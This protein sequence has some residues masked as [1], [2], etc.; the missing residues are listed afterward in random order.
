MVA[1]IIDASICNVWA[2]ET[3]ALGYVCV[4]CT[5]SVVRQTHACNAFATRVIVSAC[6]Q[7][8]YSLGGVKQLSLTSVGQLSQR[9]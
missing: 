4:C 1:I 3:V 5:K 8:D 6:V 7:S 2:P 9:A